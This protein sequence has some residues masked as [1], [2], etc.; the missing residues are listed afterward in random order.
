MQLLAKG[1]TSQT[2]GIEINR[3]IIILSL[4]Q[5]SHLTLVQKS[6]VRVHVWPL[7]GVFNGNF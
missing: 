2:T 3:V 7:C 6:S 1:L 4:R 5:S